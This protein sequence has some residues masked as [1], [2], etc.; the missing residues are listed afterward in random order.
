MASF[1]VS[2]PYGQYIFVYTSNRYVLQYDGECVSYC[3]GVS[4][5]YGIISV[6]V[7]ACVKVLKFK[8]PVWF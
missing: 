2:D 5:C 6:M 4:L 8:L 1:F 3:Y 7:L